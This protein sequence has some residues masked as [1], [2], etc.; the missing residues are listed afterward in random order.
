METHNPGKAVKVF[1]YFRIYLPVLL[2]FALVFFVYFSYIFTY[3]TPLLHSET[4][5]EDSFPL[6]H[7]SDI[8]NGYSKAMTLFWI[9]TVCLVLL[10]I[11]LLRA[12]FMNPGY[13]PD[14][15]ELEY[16][17]IKKNSIIYAR[18]K[19]RSSDTKKKGKYN[20]LES[21]NSKLTD[22][23]ERNKFLNN[24]NVILTE[25]P[26][27]DKEFDRTKEEI[28][29]HVGTENA[30][31][32]DEFESEDE[33]E[34]ANFNKFRGV[35]LSKAVLCQSCLRWKVERSHHCR[36]CGR[37]VL[38][39][40]HHCPWLANCVGFRNYKFFCL[41]HLYGII[42]T[43]VILF[44]YWEVIINDNINYE[45]NVLE[46]FFSFFVYI[47]TIGL[48]VFLLWLFL[49]NWKLVLTGQTIIENADRVRFPSNTVNNY[50]LGT[51]RNF[52]TV[53]GKNPLV[54]FIPFFPNHEGDG[55]FYETFKH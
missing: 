54:W 38:K 7:T 4:F 50:D 44:T 32:I 27:T 40:D 36:H 6:T 21:E 2:I 34:V 17:I 19:K 42:A 29:K 35:D 33:A 37:C 3:I 49:V 22:D 1:H 18:Q 43:L 55:I 31:L 51:Y 48:F 8:K 23:M 24:F 13:F 12:T 20:S 16:N 28:N 53:F 52:C 46:V 5:T 41:V 39:M 45:T 25:G 30:I 26:L 47:C 15:L 9:V 14:P 10:S 11:A